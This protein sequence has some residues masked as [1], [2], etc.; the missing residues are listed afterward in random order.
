[1][2]IR[3]RDEW[4][5]VATLNEPDRRLSKAVVRREAAERGTTI[6]GAAGADDLERWVV[7]LEGSQPGPVEA[8]RSH[9]AP[10]P[11]TGRAASD[12]MC[13]ARWAQKS[14][15]VEKLAD[16]TETPPMQHVYMHEL[17]ATAT[18]PRPR[19]TRS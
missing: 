3:D 14:V 15:K 17:L 13:L 16:E 11:D 8:R 1:M 19:C 10:A 18:I 5:E 2:C 4:V 9:V 7:R 12:W 6:D